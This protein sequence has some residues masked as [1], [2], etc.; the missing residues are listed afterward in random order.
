MV[1]DEAPVAAVVVAAFAAEIAKAKSKLTYMDAQL[2]RMS[3][4]ARSDATSQQSLD[5]ATN[6]AESARA[7]LEKARGFLRRALEL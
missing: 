5:Q 3:T 7:R 2:T 6:D 1:G 4:L